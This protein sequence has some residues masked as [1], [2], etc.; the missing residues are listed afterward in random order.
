MSAALLFAAGCLSVVGAVLSL[1]CSKRE[2]IAQLVGCL[3]GIAAS[4]ALFGSGTLALFGHASIVR[5]PT[6][7]EFAVFSIRCDPLSGL[8]LAALSVLSLCAWIYGMSYFD[9]YAGKGIGRLGFFINLFVASMAFVVSLDNAFWFLVFFELMSLSSY[10][11]V[12]FEQSPQSLRAGLLYFIM[13]HVGYLLIMIAFLIMV[14]ATEGSFD[15]ESFRA[16]ELSPARASVVFVCAFIGFGIKAGMVPFHSWL[17]LAHPA[18]PSNV[19][20]LMSGFMVKIGVFGIV[21]VAFDLL[22]PANSQLWWGLAILIFGAVSAICGIVYAIAERDLKRTLAYCTVENIGIILLGIGVSLAAN[23]L[24]APIVAS[25]GL[26][27]SLYHTVNHALFKSAAFLGAGSV[28][29]RA[30]TRMLDEMGG[31]AR[32]MPK[33]AG[34]FLVASVA[35]CAIPPLNGF[36]SE[37]YTFQALL[38]LSFLAD[39]AARGFAVIAAATLA[40]SGALA[41]VCFVKAYGLTFCGR[42]RTERAQKAREAPLPMLLANGVLAGACVAFGLGASW[43]A[44]EFASVAAIALGESEAATVAEGVLAVNPLGN[45]AISLVLVAAVLL[46]VGLLASAARSAFRKRAGQGVRDDPWNCGYAPDTSMLPAT[47]SFASS[48][49]LFYGRIYDLRERV[50]ARKE[51]VLGFCERVVGG[52]RRLEPLADTYLV[53]GIVKVVAKLS[54]AAQRVECGDYRVYLSYVVVA[55]VVFLVLTV[56]IGEA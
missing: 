49:Q 37:W 10:F 26:L 39:S 40:V 8:F 5:F 12:V 25:I 15:F 4:A 22:G 9:E 31:L 45:T 13:A 56:V 21:K 3:F 43:V 2:R 29:F 16:A 1:L 44:P 20:A 7:I 50:S 47:S 30:H 14:V 6:P 34:M 36:A 53:E 42:P 46:A 35:I 51:L 19:S 11:L 38:D 55:L 48:T 32:P 27:A 41:V 23:A 17:P 28:I 54:R 18:A 33:T 52:V 24:E